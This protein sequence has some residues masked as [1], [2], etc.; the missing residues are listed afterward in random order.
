MV[1]FL[2]ALNSALMILIPIGLGIWIIRRY[3]VRWSLFLLGGLGFIVSQ[4]GHIPFN[5]F[6]LNPILRNILTPE[7]TIP[8]TLLLAL[9][10]GL[11]AGVFEEVTRYV[12][13]RLMKNTRRWDQ[14]V[15]FG[16]GWGGFESI[17]LG[18]LSI[19]TIVNI[20]IYQSGLI[21][22]L[23]GGLA[24]ENAEAIAA[25]AAQIEA[26]VNSPPY[27]FL[28]GAVERIFAIVLQISLSILVLQAIVRRNIVWLLAAI[29]WHTLVNAT[30]VFGALQDWN[31]LLIEGVVGVFALAS[32][33]IIRRLRT[34][35]PESG[36][37]E[38]S[39][40]PEADPGESEPDLDES[41]SGRGD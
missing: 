2:L 29:G 10:L 36:A 24:G 8:A 31:V 17:L 13:Y 38:E 20:Y 35:R 34:E 39:S 21:D 33:L 9:M 4:I 12:F 22:S 32:F 23:A 37:G 6:I 19:F 1:Y 3:D 28:L 25:G 26:L 11:S 41:D 27:T 16:A 18:L 14:G 40:L 30:A 5:Q 7:V 15:V